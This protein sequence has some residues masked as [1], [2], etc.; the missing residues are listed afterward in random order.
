MTDEQTQQKTV[1]SMSGQRK[2]RR[3]ERGESFR[4]DWL[5]GPEPYTKDISLL[6]REAYIVLSAELG[7]VLS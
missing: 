5:P 7:S 6:L 2:W 3:Q 1:F 4:E